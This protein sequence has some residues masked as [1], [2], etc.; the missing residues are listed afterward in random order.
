[1]KWIYGIF[2]GRVG[3]GDHLLKDNFNTL[4]GTIGVVLVFYLFFF[5]RKV[6]GHIPSYLFWKGKISYV[7]VLY[8]TFLSWVANNQIKVTSLKSSVSISIQ[9]DVSN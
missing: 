8:S 2:E 3:K 7:L 9:N 6:Y 5:T 1:M 4:L